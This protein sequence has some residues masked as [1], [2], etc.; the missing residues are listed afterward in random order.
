MLFKGWHE[1]TLYQADT[2]HLHTISP[3]PGLPLRELTGLYPYQYFLYNRN[4]YYLED[5]AVAPSQN[6]LKHSNRENPQTDELN[7][8]EDQDDTIPDVTDTPRK[9]KKRLFSVYIR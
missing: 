5:L 7:V 2:H 9:T 3:P 4:E 8:E 1:F 6:L